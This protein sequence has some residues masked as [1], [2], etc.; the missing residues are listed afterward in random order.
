MPDRARAA[1]LF[2][3]GSGLRMGEVLGLSVDRVDFLRRTVRVDRQMF[4]SVGEEPV[5]APPKTKASDRTVPLRHV[6]V[7][8]LAA[9]LAKFPAGRHGLV[10]RTREP[11]RGDGPRSPR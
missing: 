5:F 11:N 8:V 7:D 3:A 2:A 4:S 10:F 1:V 6:T 9:H